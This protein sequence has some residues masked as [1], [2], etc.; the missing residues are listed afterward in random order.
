MERSGY[1]YLP[2]AFAIQQRGWER[3]ESGIDR[4]CVETEALA[5]AVVGAT[6]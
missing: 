3:R 5:A 6:W 1:T 4:Q 2:C